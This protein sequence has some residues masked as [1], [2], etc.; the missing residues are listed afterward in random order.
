MMRIASA[1][2]LASLVLGGCATSSKHN[3]KAHLSDTQSQ[4]MTLPVEFIKQPQYL[5]GPTVLKMAT[6]KHKPQIDFETYKQMTYREKQKG[7]L[8]SDMI[9]ATRRI[10]LSPYKVSSVEQMLES[11]EQG[12]PVIVFQNL[13]ASWLPAWHYSL[14]VGYDAKSEMMILHSDQIP[15]Q[16]LSYSRFLKTWERGDK[17]TYIAVP[18]QVLPSFTTFEEALDNALVFEELKNLSAAKDVYLQ[19]V[20]RWPKRFEPHSG[21]MG[22]YHQE[23]NL[24]MAISHAQRATELNPKQ[25]DL[26]YNLSLL[27]KE[28]KDEKKALNYKNKTLEIDPKRTFKF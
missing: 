6:Q 5:C 26:L 13:G 10:G 8:K 20:S 3:L 22:I 4:Q 24:K 25:P 12:H 16:S 17:W 23:K 21:L 28:N 7:S 1:C 15:N 9:S 14:L 27:Y 18:N 2:I 11:L 19:I